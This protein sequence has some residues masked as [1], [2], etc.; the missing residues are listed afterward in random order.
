MAIEMQRRALHI[1][2]LHIDANLINAR[3]KLPPIN[4][5]ERWEEDGIICIN[6]SSTAHKEACAGG[7]ANRTRKANEQIYTCTPP[8]EA[9]DPRYRNIEAALFPGGAKDNNQQND[10]RII[11]EAVQYAAILVTGDGGSKTQPG[12]ILGNR[13]RLKNMLTILSPDEAVD[14]VRSK[15]NERDNFNIRFTKE[16]GGNLPEWTGRD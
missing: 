1:G 14:F 2:V 12:G 7:N 3:Q 11:F 5:L 15:I 9:S 10:V 6:M 4:Q 16:F 8:A 13:D